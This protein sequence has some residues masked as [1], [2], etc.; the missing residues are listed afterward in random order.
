M[1]KILLVDDEE[2][3]QEAVREYLF[4]AGYEIIVASDAEEAESYFNDGLLPCLV[5]SDIQMPKKNGIEMMMWLRE[6]YPE[7]KIIAVTGGGRYADMDLLV[8]AKNLG[9]DKVF[10]KPL[11]M[12]ILLEAIQ[13]LLSGK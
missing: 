7:V 6:N 9:A 5:V 4:E 3:F 12:K 13:E 1:T 8:D 10:Q 2:V 11:R